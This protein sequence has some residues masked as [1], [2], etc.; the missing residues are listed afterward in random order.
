MLPPTA[1]VLH[2]V[3][4]SEIG[5][6]PCGYAH[7][8]FHPEASKVLNNIFTEHNQL[9]ETQGFVINNSSSPDAPDVSPSA[10]SPWTEE[11]E[12]EIISVMSELG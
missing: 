6:F 5:K 2:F 11:G 8:T 4:N 3:N 9:V 1:S 10:G 12:K 7:K